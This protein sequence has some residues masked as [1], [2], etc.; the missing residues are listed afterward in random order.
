M[1][2]K[3]VGIG[4]FLVGPGRPPFVVAEIGI[5]HNGFV[6][7]V[8]KLIDAACAAGCH[9]VKFQKRTVEVVYTQEDLAR[10]RQ[11]PSNTG[12][13]Q[14]AVKRGVLSPE[15]V[16]RLTRSDFE[17]TT[18]GDLKYAL[19]FTEADFLEIIAYCAQKGM[20][21]FA[22]PW[23]EGSVDFLEKLNPP[24]HKVASASLTDSGLLTRLKETGRPIIASTGMSTL[25]E[26]DQAVRILGEENLILMHTVST[27]PTADHHMNLRVIGT[28]QGRYPSVPIGYSGHE[29][30]ILPSVLAVALG[31]CMVERHLTLDVRNWGSDQAASLE[32]HQLKEMNDQ[33][34]RLVLIMGTGDKVVIPEEVAVQ[35]KLRRKYL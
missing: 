6:E 5:N 14:N 11:I 30:D 20:L 33:I 28:L 3:P 16:D 4:S 25:E 32:P 9:A 22:S 18:Q 31:A 34:A 13:L 26:I 2:T 7:E 27:Y 10:R 24:C 35:K 17:D 12:I 19:E 29:K 21:W 15:A 1:K 8:K 23:D